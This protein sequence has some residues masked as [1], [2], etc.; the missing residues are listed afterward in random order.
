MLIHS[1]GKTNLQSFCASPEVALG[2]L[3]EVLKMKQELL[4]LQ[5]LAAHG[6][7]FGL[8]HL[9]SVGDGRVEQELAETLDRQNVERPLGGLDEV[10]EPWHGLVRALALKDVQEEVRVSTP[11]KKMPDFVV[12]KMWG[13]NELDQMAKPGSHISNIMFIQKEAKKRQ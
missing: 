10:G 11:A 5:L 6:V 8:L 13:D 7:A 12:L 4:L 2:I 1:I 3:E 9:V